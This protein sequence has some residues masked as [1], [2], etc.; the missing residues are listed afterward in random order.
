MATAPP[1]APRHWV[2]LDAERTH[3][4]HAQVA[5]AARDAFLVTT[6]FPAGSREPNEVVQA[7]TR[8]EGESELAALLGEIELRLAH[9]GRYYRTE[10]DTLR[11][12]P[13]APA[14]R[15]IDMR[16]HEVALPGDARGAR[17]RI[18]HFHGERGG[19]DRL[20]IAMPRPGMAGRHVLAQMSFEFPRVDEGALEV[21]HARLA[22]P[23][24]AS[25]IAKEHVEAPRKGLR[26]LVEPRDY[27]RAYG[28][29]W[30]ERAGAMLRRATARVVEGPEIAGAPRPHA[31]PDK[32]AAMRAALGTARVEALR[33]RFI[34]PVTEAQLVEGGEHVIRRH[35]GK[36]RARAS[37]EQAYDLSLLEA[38]LLLEYALPAQ[39][40]DLAQEEGAKLLRYVYGYAV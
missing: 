35:I 7:Q 3:E 39:M 27:E 17:M 30:A 18:H 33:A 23:V 8:V 28:P 9:S 13:L 16:A 20:L 37:H 15:P 22:P 12:T 11:W 19:R 32:L 21:L 29:T 1:L 31:A 24:L 38:V 6:E 14:E 4:L 26:K 5:L 25:V 10:A 34:D 2:Y 36:L 40:W